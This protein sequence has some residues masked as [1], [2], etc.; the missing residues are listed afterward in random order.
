MKRE[1]IKN[2]ENSNRW[3][4]KMDYSCVFFIPVYRLI[5]DGEQVFSSRVILENL[6]FRHI[7]R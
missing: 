5:D 1:K 7:S 2:D 6:L 4:M 3:S